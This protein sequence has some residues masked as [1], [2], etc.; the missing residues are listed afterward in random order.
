VSGWPPKPELKPASPR[1]VELGQAARAA[2]YKAID[3]WE[4]EHQ[5]G[6]CAPDE[7]LAWIEAARGVLA[8][9]VARQPTPQRAGET[10]S[11]G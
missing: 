6:T 10:E 2:Y 7:R 1:E 11:E 5:W 4:H 3:G 9:L 8:A